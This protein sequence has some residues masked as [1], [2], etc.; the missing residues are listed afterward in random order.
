MYR[1]HYRYDGTTYVYVPPRSSPVVR[2]INLEGLPAELPLVPKAIWL[3]AN[4]EEQS[5]D[6]PCEYVG[7]RVDLGGPQ[8]VTHWLVI[9]RTAC[10]WAA[11]APAAYLVEATGTGYR[12]VLSVTTTSL[13]V[14]KDKTNGLRDISS[15]RLMARGVEKGLY[16][17]NG[18]AYAFVTSVRTE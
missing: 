7:E 18:K 16:Q 5:P 10:D 17:Y 3:A 12:T 15:V 2:D 14:L 4:P 13:S 6:R 1:G 9:S 8:S 11:G